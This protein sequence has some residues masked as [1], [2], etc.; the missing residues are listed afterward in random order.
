MAEPASGNNTVLLFAREGTG[1][2]AG[3]QWGDMPSAPVPHKLLVLTGAGGLGDTA[4]IENM[5]LGSDPNPRDSR[6][7]KETASGAFTFYPNVKSAAWL[8]EFALGVRAGNTG[9][10]PY[11]S[12]SKLQAGKLPSWT[13]EESYDLLAGTKYKHTL[14]ARIDKTSIKFADEGFLEYA[15][16]VMGKGVSIGDTPM[17][18]GVVDWAE[19]EVFDHLEM[20]VLKINGT[21]YLDAVTGQIDIAQNLFGTLYAAKGG[22]Q[23]RSLPRQR[24]KVTGNVKTYFADTELYDL[25]MAGTYVPFEIGWSN[26]TYGTEILLPRIRFKRKDPLVV[27]GPV[28]IQFD[29][30]ASKDGSELTSAK[31]TAITPIA[32]ADLAA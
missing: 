27:D 22:G 2:S 4:F 24:A 26:G 8:N 23:R 1:S 32:D 31:F 12:V 11:T 15:C 18:G 16:T 9:G 30:E 20:S 3:A 13:I 5:L 10:G 29:F 6:T 19:D 25:A 28:D 21:D 14:G 7:G 17:S